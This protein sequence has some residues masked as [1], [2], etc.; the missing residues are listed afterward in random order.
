MVPGIRTATC[1]TTSRVQRAYH[2]TEDQTTYLAQEIEDGFQQNKQTLAIWID[3]QK[4][5]D[6]KVW[7]D[8]LLLKLKRCGIGGNMY[9]WIKSYLHN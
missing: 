7:T 2:S 4:A 1:S 9:R 6:F 8:G 5:F 3:L